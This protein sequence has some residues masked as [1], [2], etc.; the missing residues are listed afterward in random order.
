[1]SSDAYHVRSLCFPVGHV[2]VACRSAFVQRGAHGSSSR[3]LIVVGIFGVVS[4]ICSGLILLVLILKECTSQGELASWEN[5][6]V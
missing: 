1:M 2:H 6:T 4:V 5:K 3:F